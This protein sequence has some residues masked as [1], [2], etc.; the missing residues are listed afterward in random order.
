M[1]Y[2]LHLSEE[3]LEVISSS[4]ALVRTIPEIGMSLEER[5]RFYQIARHLELTIDEL[6][7]KIQSESSTTA[8]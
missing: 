2:R 7:E 4:L 1:P 3:E 5:I 8:S 6:L